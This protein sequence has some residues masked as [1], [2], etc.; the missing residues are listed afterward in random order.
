MEKESFVNNLDDKRFAS[1]ESKAIFLRNVDILTEKGNV[2][3]DHRSIN[4][5]FL[6]DGRVIW[7]AYFFPQSSGNVCAQVHISEKKGE[8]I[9]I[10][11]WTYSKDDTLKK[12][13]FIEL[14]ITSHVDILD[15]SA[16][17]KRYSE[18][19]FQ[20]FA[21]DMQNLIKAEDEADDLGLTLATESE[22][23]EINKFLEELMRK[24]KTAI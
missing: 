18:K 21:Q 3:E 7:I 8:D 24:Q 14:P 17:Y 23:K 22:A 15:D 11:N 16:E 19:E 10:T 6:K 12:H 4:F 9:V 5:S 2:I 13:S 1:P 20:R